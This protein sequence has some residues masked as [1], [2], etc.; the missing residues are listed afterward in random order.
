MLKAPAH[1]AI[2]LLTHIGL[3]CNS[4]WYKN[5]TKYIKAFKACLDNALTNDYN[6]NKLVGKAHPL[7][8]VSQSGMLEILA[9]YA[10]LEKRYKL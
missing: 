10:F 3:Y 2:F 4:F 9:R 6:S 5:D 1:S 7:D 8:L